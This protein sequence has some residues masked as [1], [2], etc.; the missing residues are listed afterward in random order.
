LGGWSELDQKSFDVERD[1]LA[2]RETLEL[3]RAYYKIPNE[4]VPK[5]IFELIKTLAPD[6][7]R[8]GH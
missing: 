8:T 1:P 5:E 6:T 3:V 2:K 7:D 4:S